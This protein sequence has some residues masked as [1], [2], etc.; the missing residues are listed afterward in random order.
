MDIEGDP[1]CLFF[2]FFFFNFSVEFPLNI[3]IPDLKGLVWM[4]RG[5]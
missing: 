4:K 5:T 3:S 1:R 2:F